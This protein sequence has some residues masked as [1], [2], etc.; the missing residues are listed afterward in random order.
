M[1]V[2]Q[3]AAYVRARLG[4]GLS[5]RRTSTRPAAPALLLLVGLPGTGKSYVAE[6]I[7]ARRPV[8]VVRTD[9]VRK[10]LFH[11]PT[12]SPGESGFVYQTCYQIIR[13]LLS[14]GHDVVFDGT[15][16]SESGR[17]TAY[18][19]AEEVGARLLIVVT[20]APPEVVEA[21]LTQ[22]ASGRGTAFQS[23]AGWP[24]YERMASTSE[25]VRR[26]H[27]AIDTSR[28]LKRAL[29][30]VDRFLAGQPVDRWLRP[31]AAEPATDGSPL[32][33]PSAPVGSAVG[34]AAGAETENGRR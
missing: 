12:Y 31:P 2:T 7:R 20:E 26:P 15:N 13:D 30:V 17:R 1:D 19:V 18:Q 29:T 33:R 32:A 8:E 24:I 14:E 28:G 23:D 3:A 11:P 27:L 21:R 6:A 4:I 5:P 16:T 22:R 34:A 25:P 9:E 10:A